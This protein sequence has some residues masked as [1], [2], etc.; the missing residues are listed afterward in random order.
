M[1]KSLLSIVTVVALLFLAGCTTPTS[2]NGTPTPDN[3]GKEDTPTTVVDENGGEEVV[4]SDSDL[5]VLA[6]CL[7]EAGLT[8]YGTEWCSHCK[9]QKAMFGD[10]FAKVNYVDCDADKTACVAA[11]VQ[12]FPTWVDNKGDNY[13]GVQTLEKLASLAG[14]EM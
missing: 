14:C 6:S 1:K 5:G 3:T 2:D 9:T 12:G 7:T 10:N 11:G 13:P 8:M 4:L